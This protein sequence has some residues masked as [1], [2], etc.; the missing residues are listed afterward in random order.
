MEE[1]S[2][3]TNGGWSNRVED[4]ID[5]GDVEGAISL[6]ES[7]VSKLETVG[8]S[9]SSSPDDL[10]L[11]SALGDLGDLQSSR[12]FSIK[13]DELLSR[14]L[15]LRARAVNPPNLDSWSVFYFLGLG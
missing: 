10:R 6:L 9:L 12:G 5:S 13:A 11:A 15:L 3:E 4:L 7:V 8:S 1:N 14:A 2:Q